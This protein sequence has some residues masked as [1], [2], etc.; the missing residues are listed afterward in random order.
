MKKI[1]LS[2]L[3]SLSFVIFSQSNEDIRDLVKN[4]PKLVKDYQNQM[5]SDYAQTIGEDTSID[6]AIENENDIE[7]DNEEPNIFGFQYINTIPKSI[8]S[9]S[10]L[11]VPNDYVISLGDKLKIILTGGEK[12]IYDLAVGMDGNILLP[13]IGSISVAGESIRDVREKVEQLI[14]LSY[15]GTKVSISLDSLAARKINIIGA[16][17]NPGTYIVSPF[18]T[19]TSS[20]AYSGGFE[21]Y[22]SLRNITVIREGEEINFD[23]YDFLIFGSRESD[24][25]IR[26]GD[27]I[28]IKSTNNFVEILGAINRPKIYEYMP[29]DTY[30]DLINFALGLNRYGDDKNITATVI[31]GSKKLT[32]KVR[33]DS[34]IDKQNIEALYIGN[35]VNINSRDVFV[36]GD[37]VTSGFYQVTEDKKLEKFLEN[38]QFSSEIYPFYSIYERVAVSGLSKISSSFSLSDPDT[39]SNLMASKNTTLSFFGRDQIDLFNSGMSE[40]EIEDSSLQMIRS[41][42]LVSISL[43]D[44]TLTIPLKGKISP[45]QIHLFFGSFNEIDE[46]KVSV[47]TNEDI[48]TNAYESTFDSEDLVA[49]SFP[50]IKENIIEVTIE[51]EILNAG[52]YFVPSSTNLS[53]LYT[54][55]GGLRNEAFTS[56]IQVFRE[57]I[58]EKQIK[59]IRE[60]KAVLTDAMIHKSS[61]ISDRGML[62]IESILLLS[63]LADPTGRV[64]GNFDPNSTTSSSF[65]LKEGDLISIPS[66]SYE[67]IVQGEVLNSSSFI[68][69]KSMKYKDYIEAAGG[70]SDY[71]DKRAV[72][73]IRANGLS[74]ET[75]SSIFSGETIIYPGDTIVV[76]RNLD[77]FEA[78]PL[79]SMATNI[80][81]DIAFSAASLN[82][83]SD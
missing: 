15:V 4:N 12:G 51:G 56:G 43:P 5:D 76:P 83:I 22:A 24:I 20:L 39:Y 42:D 2:L 14:E 18:S 67:V 34:S 31:E 40:I 82:A 11:P 68:F 66:M 35:N 63:E 62:D 10:D 36:S 49:I 64:A 74:V 29:Q 28:S 59:A 30:S 71:A 58:K 57:E 46:D 61:S 72:F 3:I 55:A 73:I 9:T 7:I 16:V 41:E 44:K 33:K 1:F 69:N 47:I 17:K 52:T 45:K 26:Q 50:S 70:F 48:F 37:S 79:V 60:A 25:N 38:L 6:E 75:S 54:L 80:I 81:A 27:T 77:Q 19:I 8:S 23:L 21:E 53:D 32:K 78:L 65:V 13:D